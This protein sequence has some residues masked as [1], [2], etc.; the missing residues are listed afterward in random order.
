MLP[1]LKNHPFEL[2]YLLHYAKLGCFSNIP[3]TNTHSKFTLNF[4]LVLIFST[5]NFVLYEYLTSNNDDNIPITKLRMWVKKCASKSKSTFHF[6]CFRITDLST[7]FNYYLQMCLDRMQ[8]RKSNSFDPDCCNRRK[9]TISPWQTDPMKICFVTKTHATNWYITYTFPYIFIHINNWNCY[10]TVSKR[11]Q[12]G[13][14]NSRKKPN[15]LGWRHYKKAHNSN[16]Q[17]LVA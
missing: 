15:Q 6:P 3:L 2:F 12:Q 7:N 16:S 17:L 5:Y 13:N 4:A 8:H 14:T 9:G 10:F 1:H 11:A